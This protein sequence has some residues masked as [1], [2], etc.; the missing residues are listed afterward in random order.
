MSDTTTIN[1]LSYLHIPPHIT[2]LIP[3]THITHPIIKYLTVSLQYNRSSRA[4]D[5]P[6]VEILDDGVEDVQIVHQKRSGCADRPII[7]DIEVN[8]VAFVE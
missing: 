2:H 3:I 7:K 1:C 5:G 8:D 4:I 6:S